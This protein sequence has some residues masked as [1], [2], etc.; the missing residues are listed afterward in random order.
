MCKNHSNG[1]T[2]SHIRI[3]LNSHRKLFSSEKSIKELFIGLSAD[4]S[5]DI[6][7]GVGG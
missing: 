4:F 3:I 1:K 6:V 2:Q 7:I 5:A